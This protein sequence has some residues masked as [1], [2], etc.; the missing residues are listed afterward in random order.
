MSRRAMGGLI[1]VLLAAQ[2]LAV[3]LSSHAT[4]VAQQQGAMVLRVLTGRDAC[5]VQ[6]RRS[7]DDNWGLKR[8]M[9]RQ[10]LA[11]AGSSTV[12]SCPWAKRI[13]RLR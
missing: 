8:W 7:D 13:V 5:E 12:T 3:S 2:G 9:V 4:A 10:P 11:K 1:V 6:Y